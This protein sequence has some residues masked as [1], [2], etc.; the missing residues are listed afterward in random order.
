VIV[1]E[2]WVVGEYVEIDQ[3]GFCPAHAGVAA[4]EADQCPGCVGG[5]GDCGMWEAFTNRY[6]RTVTPADYASLE[7]G[8]CPRRVNGTMVVNNVPGKRTI[9]S[10]D[11]SAPAV[12]GGRAF[13]QAIREYIV[14]F[15]GTD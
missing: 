7:S 1:P 8:V 5:W 10:I 2:G 4:F 13:A 6:R 3:E 9:E 15:G 14:E 12:E 11:L